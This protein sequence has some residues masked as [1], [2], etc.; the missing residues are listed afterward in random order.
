M[1]NADLPAPGS[2]NPAV[3]RAE[4]LNALRNE[5]QQLERETETHK[6]LAH[7]LHDGL[8]QDVLAARMQLEAISS[9]GETPSQEKIA[10]VTELLERAILEARQLV[11]DLHT[12]QQTASLTE[13]LRSLAKD[14]RSGMLGGRSLLVVCQL[15][16]ISI[17]DPAVMA[18]LLRVARESLVNAA[19]H[20]GANEIQLLLARDPDALLRLE[21]T[22]EGVGFDYSDLPADRFGLAGMRERVTA[23]S[24]QLEIESAVGQGTTIRATFPATGR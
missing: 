7:E 20:S 1:M 22:D 24:G 5:Y 4:L 23:L 16:E 19:R 14:C 13:A 11:G 2:E 18:T 10:M 8:L 15:E 21:I 17:E 3:T 6:W 12:I 9:S